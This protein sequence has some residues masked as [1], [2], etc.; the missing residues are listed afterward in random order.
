[1]ERLDMT[2]ESPVVW[3]VG[4]DD[5]GLSLKSSTVKARLG[6]M[7]VIGLRL[8]LVG[9]KKSCRWGGQGYSPG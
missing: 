9:Y 2:W 8:N 4:R 6:Y 5:P 3:G 7:L 1:M